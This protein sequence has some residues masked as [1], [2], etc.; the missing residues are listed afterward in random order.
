MQPRFIGCPTT[1]W[2]L[3]R[4]KEETPTYKCEVGRRRYEGLPQLDSK[5]DLLAHSKQVHDETDTNMRR[6]TTGIRSEKCIVMR[7]RRCANVIV[8]LHKPR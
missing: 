8:Y 1:I 2:P 3:H 7:F 6:L 4:L 5:P